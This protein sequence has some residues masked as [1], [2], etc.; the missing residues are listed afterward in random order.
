MIMD[1]E[2]KPPVRHAMVVVTKVNVHCDIS[3]VNI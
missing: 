1:G 3:L 2:T